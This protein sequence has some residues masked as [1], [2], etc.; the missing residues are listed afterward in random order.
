MEP[1]ITFVSLKT[2]FLVAM[3]SSKQVGTGE[4]SLSQPGGRAFGYGATLWAQHPQGQAS[5]RCV[6]RAAGRGGGQDDPIAGSID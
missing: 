5:P 6:D 2:A 3:V 4:P 1:F